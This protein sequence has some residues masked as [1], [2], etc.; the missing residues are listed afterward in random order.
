MN[1]GLSLSSFQEKVYE[2]VSRIPK[3]RVSTY[4]E[5]AKALGINSPRAVGQALK[6]NPYSPRV[7]CHRVV[8]SDGSIG[9]FKGSADDTAQK[10]K[11]RLLRMEGITIIGGKV[12]DFEKICVTASELK[13]K[14]LR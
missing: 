9:G 10:Q 3:G 11:I 6:S 2:A 14:P 5:V 4:K 1:G 13:E 7:P 8:M 12:A